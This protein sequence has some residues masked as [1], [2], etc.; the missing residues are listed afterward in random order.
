VHWYDEIPTFVQTPPFLHGDDEQAISNEILQRNILFN[1]FYQYSHFDIEHQNIDLHKYIDTM[2]CQSSHRYH[3]FCTV[4]MNKLYQTR[5]CKEIFYF[6]FFTVIHR[7]TLGAI[8]YTRASTLIRWSANIRTST[9]IITWSTC[10]Y[11]QYFFN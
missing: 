7:L 4:L 3:R 11:I 6:I 9:T 8:V 2:K 1:I 5:Q 10:T